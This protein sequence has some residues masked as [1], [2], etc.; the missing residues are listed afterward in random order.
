MITL[1]ELEDLAYLPE[2]IAQI[3]GEISGLKRPSYLMDMDTRQRAECAAALTDLMILLQKQR[4]ACATQ[5][6]RLQ[7]FVDS[8][9]DPF[10]RELFQL[11]YGRAMEWG[12]VSRIITER[13]FY[14]EEGS[15]R[16]MCRRY[17]ER[18]GRNETNQNDKKG[19]QALV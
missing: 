3:D 4:E 18:C 13:G 7:A 2:E 6:K 17:I 5:L 14:Y 10:I 19:T 11:R 1:G 8:I 12:Q 9:D 16:Q 15:L